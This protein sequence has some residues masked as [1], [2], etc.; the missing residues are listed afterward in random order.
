MLLNYFTKGIHQNTWLLLK[1]E[2]VYAGKVH[3]LYLLI[4]F[5][6]DQQ[7]NILLVGFRV[8]G[9]MVRKS[10]GSP[11]QNDSKHVVH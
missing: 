5:H 3:C 1:S 8:I 2:A 10:C 7:S 6:F 9:Y 11:S 4:H